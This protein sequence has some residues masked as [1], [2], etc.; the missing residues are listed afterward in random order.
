MNQR[1]SIF[2]KEK[3]V[4]RQREK[5]NEKDIIGIKSGTYG[6]SIWQRI[7]LF[8]NIIPFNFHVKV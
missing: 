2:K 1:N 8:E 3:E 4:E 7:Y 6:F 5:E